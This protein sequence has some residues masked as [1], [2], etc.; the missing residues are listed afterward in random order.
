M[1]TPLRH[2]GMACIL[3]GSHS[4]TCTPRIHPPTEWTIPA[5]TFPAEAGTHLPTPE[6]WKAELALKALAVLSASPVPSISLNQ[7]FRK[8]KSK[9]AECP[10]NNFI[11]HHFNQYFVNNNNNNNNLATC[12]YLAST[13]CIRS[14]HNFFGTLDEIV[15]ESI[16]NS[17]SRVNQ[18]DT[19]MNT[20]AYNAAITDVQGGS[21]IQALIKSMQITKRSLLVHVMRQFFK[22]YV[23]RNKD[24]IC[25]ENMQN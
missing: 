5:F 9:S 20:A 25:S 7:W 16:R 22:N 17:R 23:D 13:L 6:G 8:D 12:T 11:K 21:N 18:G 1:I 4:F 2:S 15:N 3:K 19:E 24:E 14:L 10:C